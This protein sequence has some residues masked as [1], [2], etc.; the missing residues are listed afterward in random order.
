MEN[1]NSIFTPL[2]NGLVVSCQARGNSPFNSPEGVTIL[3]QAAKLGGAVGIR[4]EGVL[5]TKKIINEVQLP[6]IGLVKSD[7]ADGT[8]RITGTYKDVEDLLSIGTPIL[9]STVR[10]ENVKG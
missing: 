2:K 10:S 9:Q 1:F 8:V 6:V 3:A 4:S 7:F 5:K